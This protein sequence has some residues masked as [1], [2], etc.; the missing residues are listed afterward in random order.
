MI[1]STF[2]FDSLEKLF[3]MWDLIVGKK[4]VYSY[5]FIRRTYNIQIF[6]EEEKKQYFGIKATN[7]KYSMELRGGSVFPSEGTTKNFI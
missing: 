2:E 5:N 7:A 4:I 6:R 1:F 3:T